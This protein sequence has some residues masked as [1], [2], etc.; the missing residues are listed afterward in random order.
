MDIV[1]VDDH[2]LF[3]DGLS[4]LIKQSFASATVTTAINASQ[5]LSII[6]GLK[7][8][9]DIILLDLNLPGISGLTL[10]R[11]LQQSSIWSPII[12]ISASESMMDAKIALEH[13]TSGYLPKSTNSETL[14][15]AINK[16]LGGEIYL[17]DGWSELLSQSCKSNNSTDTTLTPRQYEILHLMSQGLSNKVIAQHLKVSE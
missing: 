5:A 14:C 7:S 11:Q 1:I 8:F 16:V 10:A 15:L 13:G 2:Q 3:L 17:P 6:Q 4:G 9:P 12:I